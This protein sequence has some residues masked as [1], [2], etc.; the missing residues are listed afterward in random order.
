M[1]PLPW[2]AMPPF[3]VLFVSL[4]A[5]ASAPANTIHVPGDAPTIQAG[6]DLAVTGDVVLVAPGTYTGTGN[7]NLDF[8]GRDIEVRS[9]GGADVTIIDCEGS[10][11]GFFLLAPLTP[12]AAVDGFTIRHGDIGSAEGG[13]GMILL[14][15]SPTISN[16]VFLLNT[17][18][19]DFGNGGGGG[20]ACYNAAPAF[21]GCAFRQN[22]VVGVGAPGGGLAAHES[23]VTLTDC[24]F[25]D[26]S[27]A[28]HGAIGGAVS[29]DFNVE[30]RGSTHP[31]LSMIQDCRFRGN[32][33]YDAGGLF[34]IDA[35]IAHCEFSAN[36]A[37]NSGGGGS[38]IL[39]TVN[40]CTFTDNRAGNAGGGLQVS[41]CEVSRSTFTG[42]QALQGGGFWTSLD[43]SPLT[44]CVFTGNQAEI[45]GAY[46]GRFPGPIQNCT[47]TGDTAP[48]GSE[49]HVRAPAGYSWTIDNSIVAF[50]RGGAGVT[51]LGITQLVASC[52][53]IFGNEGGD[54][55]GC[56][57]GQLGQDGNIAEDPLFCDRQAADFSLCADSPCAP[58]Q[59]GACGLVGALP[60]G[61]AACGATAV[62]PTTWGR[63]KAGA[64][65]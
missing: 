33:A 27:A 58:G 13:G 47:F 22:A 32:G 12:A 6:I 19:G 62:E 37:V 29:I 4:L 61:C 20:V 39:S 16:C 28:G 1:R 41:G 36:Q 3:L 43:P 49:I 21:I 53:D 52:C 64:G 24:A 54:W 10:G 46:F 31:M 30:D 48:D 9:D 11:R 5:V 40:A 44:Y 7:K 45:G 50:G 8:R 38:L 34:A 15:A 63:I 18:L 56:L 26:N 59:S 51:C 2:S 25:E 55:V 42:N 14:G 57:A 60:E 23:V 35:S 65:R 17:A